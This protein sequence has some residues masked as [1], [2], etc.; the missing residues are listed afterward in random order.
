MGVEKLKRRTTCRALLAPNDKVVVAW[1]G[2]EGGR[3]GGRE[4]VEGG[5]EGGKEGVSKFVIMIP[6]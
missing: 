1:A 6:P 4:E 2:R 3:E 5:R